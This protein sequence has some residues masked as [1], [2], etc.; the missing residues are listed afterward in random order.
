MKPLR[1][2]PEAEVELLEVATWYA[3]RGGPD[4]ERRLLDDTAGVLESVR[5]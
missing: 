2:D 3:E 4:L 1:I 5:R